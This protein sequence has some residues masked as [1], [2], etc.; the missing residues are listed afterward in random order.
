MPEEV[1]NPLSQVEIQRV[2]GYHK[3][4]DCQEVIFE[5]KVLLKLNGRSHRSFYCLPTH[6]EGMARGY[7]VSEG[8]C[9]PS[10]IKGIEVRTE[11]GKFVVEATIHEHSTKLNKIK[12]ELKISIADVWK[13]NERLIAHDALHKKTGGTHVVEIFSERNSVTVEDISRHCAVDKVIGLALQNG[14]N[15]TTSSLITSCRQTESTIRKAIY[16]QISIVISLAAVTTLAT[17]SAQKYGITL[18]GFARDRNF[19]IYSHQERVVENE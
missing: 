10:D 13:A 6:L 9:R 5:D 1:L 16:S 7:L 14:I 15:L 18:I 17:E 3:K 2:S 12:T 8:M 4:T 11:E 19:S